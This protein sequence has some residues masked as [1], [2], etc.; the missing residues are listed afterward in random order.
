MSTKSMNYDHAAYLTRMPVVSGVNTA[1]TSFPDAACF[2]GML[3]MSA[4]FT[5]VTAGTSATNNWV[6]NKISGTT[7]TAL[8]TATLGTSVVG[9]VIN[10][11]LSTTTGGVACLQG[12][13]L[14]AAKGTDTVGVSALVY[15]M[16]L[17]PLATITA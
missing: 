2:T 14:F 5:V 11:P 3:A 1:N 17:Q 16:A 9:T 13:L 10:V 8:A 15:E 4:T 7:I 12:D 6:I